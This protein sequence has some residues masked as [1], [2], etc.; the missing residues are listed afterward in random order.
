MNI[1]KLPSGSYQ[2]RQ[3]VKGKEYSVTLD[4]KPTIYEA[5]QL[6]KEKSDTKNITFEKACR[7]YIDA[8]SNILSPSTIVSYES[9]IRNTSN[10]LLKTKLP[11]LNNQIIQQEVN[12]YAAHHS[13]KS[14]RNFNG[15]LMSVVKFYALNIKSPNL[16][17]KTPKKVF[18]PSEE[19]IK[20]IYDEIKGTKYEV[21]I[22]LASMGLRR[23]EI[24]ALTID[25][26]NGNTLTINKAL[27]YDKNKQW[28]VK[29]TKTE[30]STRT[31]QVPDYVADL[32]REQGYVYEGFPGQIYKRL[33]DIEKKLDIPHFSL[34]K[35]RHFFASYMH[36][37]GYTDK[38]IQA[39][40]GWKT[41]GVMKTVY[42][43]EM[44]MEKAKASM[45]NNFGTLIDNKKTG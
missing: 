29:E 31:I 44:E 43:H 17:P 8:K 15:F 19:Q 34:H 7:N 24:C 5:E 13:S 30:D 41:D 10:D 37:L 39:F 21:A 35:M 11:N 20:L 26:L 25:D 16:P 33:T 38:Q 3:M 18:I 45:S 6:I 22:I 42:Q 23:S 32:I 36:Q 12:E 1:R 27:V 40:G 2:I 4:H 9:I 14:T 28:I